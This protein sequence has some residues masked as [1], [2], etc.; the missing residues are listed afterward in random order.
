ME[1]G[2]IEEWVTVIGESPLLQTDRADTGRIIESVQLVQVPL[3]FNRN[4]QG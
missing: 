1:V 2:T 3:G 4:F